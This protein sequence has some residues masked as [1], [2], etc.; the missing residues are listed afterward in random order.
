VRPLD[1][2]PGALA[3]VEDPWLLAR[4]LFS[5][6]YIGGWTAAEHWELT[7][8]LFRSVFVV[9]AAPRKRAHERRASLEFKIVRVKPERL[10]GATSVWRGDERVAV[11]DRERTIVDA[12]VD[13]SWVGGVRHL[14]EMLEAY[15]RGATFDAAK[16]LARLSEA[17]S[18]AAY[19]RMGFLAELLWPAEH[20]IV[21]AARTHVTKGMIRLDPAVKSHGRMSKRWGLWINTSLAHEGGDDS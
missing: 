7:E 2:A 5:P 17:G 18:G 8:Q 16:L 21:D 15:R 14:A 3:T 20:A 9:T 1:S 13:P 11:S 4:E 10:R 12:L 6:C 19:K